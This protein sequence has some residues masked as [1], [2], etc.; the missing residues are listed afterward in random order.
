M[1]RPSVALA[2]ATLAVGVPGSQGAGT[3]TVP[4]TVR[5]S[6]FHV[7]LSLTQTRIGPGQAT[8]AIATV[9]NVGPERVRDV[10]L[11][12]RSDPSGVTVTGRNPRRV[13]NLAT[14]TSAGAE[15][16]ICGRG[17]AGYLLVAQARGNLPSGEAVTAE[18]EARL[19]TM[20]GPPA[21]R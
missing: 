19:L 5:V 21:C 17:P 10:M 18:S 7:T 20:T 2:L 6:P 3:D 16:T 13:G 14:G 9:T 15:W 12:L 1:T 4:A 8:H 11:E